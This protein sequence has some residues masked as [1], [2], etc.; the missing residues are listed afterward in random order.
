MRCAR[1]APQVQVRLLMRNA[2]LPHRRDGRAGALAT[3][4]MACGVEIHE[5]TPAFPC[6]GDAGRR[7]LG[8]RRLVNIDPISL[9][10]NLEA[11]L[12]VRDADF[13]ADLAREISRAIA[14]S[15]PV[16]PQRLRSG[17]GW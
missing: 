11:N 17:A 6:Q 3:S 7:A 2:G 13:G 5:H 1:P 9:L 4:L 8:D 10:L 16:T 15:E 12:I 14:V